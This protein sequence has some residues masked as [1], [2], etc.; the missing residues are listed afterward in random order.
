MFYK[1]FMTGLLSSNCYILGEGGEAAV[2][3]PGAKEE[4]IK[5]VLA[6]QQ[7]S[8]KYIILTHAHIDHICRM[9]QLHNSCGGKVVVHKDDAPL[10]GNPLLNAAFL[11]GLDTVFNEADI[12]V[13]DGDILEIG[14]LKLEILHTPGHTPGSMC[15][16]AGDELFTGDTLFRLGVGRTDL[17]A[18]DH[19]LLMKSL[20]KLMTLNDSIKVYPGH[21]SATDIGYERSNN[22]YMW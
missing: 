12:C 7:L 6:A 5:Q 8:L 2:I 4:D 14:G 10:L 17:G 20:K 13:K 22:M 18:G 9:E 11:F 19:D 16:R 3:D 21:G 15:I 1:R